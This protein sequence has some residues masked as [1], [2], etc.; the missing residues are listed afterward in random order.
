MVYGFNRAQAD[1]ERRMEC[2]YD[3]GG[4]LYEEEEQEEDSAYWSMVDAQ[5]E[6]YKL[7]DL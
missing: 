3:V 2:P 7:G 1:Y 5:M 6:A 4:A